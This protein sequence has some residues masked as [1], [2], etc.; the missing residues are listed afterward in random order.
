V[1]I[2]AAPDKFR[3]S[4]T[5]NEAAEAIARGARCAFPE[6]IVVE[7]PVAD[8]GE[9]TVQALARAGAYV[10][11]CEARDPLGTWRRADYAVRGLTAYIETSQ[12]CG[13]S[14][15]TPSPQV[16]MAASTHGVGD[17]VRH[18]LNQGVAEVVLCLGGSATTDGG[19]GMLE[20]LGARL[21]D[22]HGSPVPPGGGGLRDVAEIDLTALHPRGHVVE[23]RIASDVTNSLLGPTGAAAV[24]GPQKGADR[25]TVSDLDRGLSLWADLLANIGGS[26]VES[27]RGSGSA[28]GLGVP[29][30]SL[31][32]AS[33]APGADLVLDAVGIE[34][35]I[36]G[37]DLVVTGEGSFD[38]QSLHGKAPAAVARLAGNA[39]VPVLLVAG[40]IDVEPR[41]LTA[42]GIS[43]SQS[44]LDLCPDLAEAIR[45]ADKLVPR[46][47][48]RAL[49]SWRR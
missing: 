18:A 23:W 3:G 2:G 16:A 11:S 29:V 6:A 46:A 24:F 33:I 45:A 8:G 20:A 41:L 34:G 36:C 38:R 17:I 30:L 48:C 15:V 22:S 26:R 7:C 37:A 31:F 47:V 39:N 10:Q 19:A 25:S 21:L 12:A 40:R 32:G 5:A 49:R 4:L 13:A 28:G 43:M 35:K 27:A 42:L 9:G 14:L 1:R 44:L